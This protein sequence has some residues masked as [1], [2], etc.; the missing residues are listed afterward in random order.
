[1]L[2]RLKNKDRLNIDEFTF[3]CSIGKNG[4]RS[5]SKKMVTV[6]IHN[7]ITNQID[8]KGNWVKLVKRGLRFYVL[9]SL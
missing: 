6:A 1:M 8:P 3:K 4:L 5:K 9:E 7:Y 2:I